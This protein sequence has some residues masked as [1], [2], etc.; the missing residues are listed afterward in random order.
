MKKIVPL[1]LLGIIIILVTWDYK[2]PKLE[3]SNNINFVKD[4]NLGSHQVISNE[5]D[6]VEN[7]EK[8]DKALYNHAGLN[9][10]QA[11][12]ILQFQSSRGYFDRRQ[13]AEYSS[14]DLPT[15]DALAKNGDIKA[16]QVLAVEKLKLGEVEASHQL[17][18]DA[19]V[20]GSTQALNLAAGDRFS[21]YALTE[22]PEDKESYLVEAFALIY[23][24][25]RR[26]DFIATDN[27][28]QLMKDIHRVDLTPE[29]E[30]KISKKADQLYEYLESRRKDI[31]LDSFSNTVA[32]GL[33]IPIN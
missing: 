12:K 25:K 23:V 22:N 29:Q 26:G 11:D 17:L 18:L 31:G 13:L 24:S 7:P 9:A 33:R 14:Y 8:E 27:Y 21:S 5:H 19:A 32:A 1:I 4:E 16:M 15:L 10:F 6:D 20:Y 28:I 3:T 2:A 30:K